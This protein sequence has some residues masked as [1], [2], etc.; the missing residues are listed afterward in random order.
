MKT[1]PYIQ[2]FSA[3]TFS[4]CSSKAICTPGIVSPASA[5]ADTTNARSGCMNA[6]SYQAPSPSFI[7]KAL[8][9]RPAFHFAA[10]FRSTI[11]SPPSA[12]IRSMVSTACSA[13]VQTVVSGVG[14][15]MDRTKSSLSAYVPSCAGA[16]NHTADTPAQSLRLDLCAET[17]RENPPRPAHSSPSSATPSGSPTDNALSTLFPSRVHSDDPSQ[18]TR[19]PSIFSCISHPATGW[20]EYVASSIRF[21]FD[22]ILPRMYPHKGILSTAYFYGASA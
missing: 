20:P 14:R 21:G 22:F 15:R 6:F 1:T 3:D 19:I 9:E 2:A 18:Y 16:S 17:V 10:G 11:P 4:A 8:R 5:D 7:F 13:L 12:T